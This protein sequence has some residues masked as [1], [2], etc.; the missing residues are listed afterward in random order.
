[1]EK[2][3]Q[4]DTVDSIRTIY[5]Q[6]NVVMQ[7]ENF[8]LVQ[9]KPTEK[10]YFVVP[11]KAEKS[12]ESFSC[13]SYRFLNFMHALGSLCTQYNKKLKERNVSGSFVATADSYDTRIKGYAAQLYFQ[14]NEE[15]SQKPFER[16]LRAQSGFGRI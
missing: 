7:N 2:T 5:P 11:V 10:D 3:I 14:K 9:K 4:N 1:M 15:K 6:S 12:Y 8:L 13:H 16:F